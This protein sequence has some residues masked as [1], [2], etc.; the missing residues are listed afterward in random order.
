MRN[1]IKWVIAF[2]IALIGLVILA[3]TGSAP[4]QPT[5]TYTDLE[6]VDGKFY[7]LAS[8]GTVEQMTQMPPSGGQPGA[9]TW[10][11]VSRW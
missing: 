2:A 10:G 11:P 4:S 9:A 1:E 5:T 8:D 6:V 7:R 3:A